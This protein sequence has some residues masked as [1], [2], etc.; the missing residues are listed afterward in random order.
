MSRNLKGGAGKNFNFAFS[1]E[2]EDDSQDSPVKNGRIS[3]EDDSSG[4]EDSVQDQK[5]SKQSF[6]PLNLLG[7][8]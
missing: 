4:G 1:S 8:Q 5:A 7:Q 2:G 3:E 6:R